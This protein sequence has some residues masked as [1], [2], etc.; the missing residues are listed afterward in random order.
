MFEN[1]FDLVS[2]IQHVST[3]PAEHDG[4]LADIFQ[5]IGAQDT[6]FHYPFLQAKET[7]F[8]LAHE[9]LA[10]ASLFVARTLA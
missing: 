9:A 1:R 6:V 8:S 2:R 4:S 10:K 3:C 7:S 5:T